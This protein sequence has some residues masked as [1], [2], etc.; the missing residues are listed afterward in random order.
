[1]VVVIASNGGVTKRV[2]TFAGRGR[3]RPGRVGGEL[4]ER[5]PG[6][7]SASARGWPPTGSPTPSWARR[8]RE[9]PRAR[10]RAAF[11][12]LEESAEETLYVDG[13]A[14]LLSEEHSAD[15]PHAEELMRALERRVNAARARCARRSTSARCSS[16]SAA[17][18]R[19]PSC[20]RSASSAPTT[21]S[22]TATSARS[23]SWGRCGWTTRTA[24]AS[25][26]EAAGELS[27]FFETVYDE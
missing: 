20:A 14:R 16:G 11:T 17:R 27:R 4:P 2:F 3:P 24:I 15:L 9:L 8:E 1:M 21:G 5:A 12:S 25:V 22:A 19:S 18:T 10:S 23:A 6:R 26:R 7:A 13:A